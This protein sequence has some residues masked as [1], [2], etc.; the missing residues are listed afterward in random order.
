M[1]YMQRAT[2]LASMI[3][4]PPVMRMVTVWLTRLLVQ[5]PSSCTS[6]LQVIIL[7]SSISNIAITFSECLFDHQLLVDSMMPTHKADYKDSDSR[8]FSSHKPC[9][10]IRHL[11]VRGLSSS[12]DSLQQVRDKN[13]LR[14]SFSGLPDQCRKMIA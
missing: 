12:G 6:F 3:S 5:I 10:R 14:A 13:D 7:Y 8:A 2:A 9:V 11:L 4:N 1:K